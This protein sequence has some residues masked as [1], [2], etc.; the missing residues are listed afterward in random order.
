MLCSV[1]L[2]RIEKFESWFE[3]HLKNGIVPRNAGFVKCRPRGAQSGPERGRSSHKPNL[4][5]KILLESLL[6][7]LSDLILNNSTLDNLVTI[8]HFEFFNSALNNTTS[9]YLH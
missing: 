9:R 3:I 7:I 6:S 8:S 5:T 2:G 1:K 4:V